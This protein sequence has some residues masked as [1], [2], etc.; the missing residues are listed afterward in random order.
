MIKRSIGGCRVRCSK[1]KLK[2]LWV[3]ANVDTHLRHLV[4]LPI[5]DALRSSL[6]WNLFKLSVVE[7]GVNKEPARR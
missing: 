6:N 2:E 5:S 1:F 4:P 7:F 3:G